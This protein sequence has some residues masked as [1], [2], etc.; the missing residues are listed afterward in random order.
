MQSQEANNK[1]KRPSIEECRKHLGEDA[2]LM[3]DK[4]VEDFYDALYA[5]LDSVLDN[6]L[7]HTKV[8]EEV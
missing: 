2:K 4:Q 8:S 6:Y 3:S 5:V 7:L 1:I